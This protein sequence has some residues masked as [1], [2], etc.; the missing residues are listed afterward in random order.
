MIVKCVMGKLIQAH[1]KENC[2]IEEANEL[3]QIREVLDNLIAFCL[4]SFLYSDLLSGEY[5]SG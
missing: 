1:T 5:D 3:P 4:S 2:W